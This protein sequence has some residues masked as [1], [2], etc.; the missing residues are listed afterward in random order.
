MVT[1][2]ERINQI[3]KERNLRQVDVLN[4]AKPYQ[5]K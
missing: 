3:M 5:E 1:S 4:M 2:T